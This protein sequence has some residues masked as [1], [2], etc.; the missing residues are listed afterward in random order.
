MLFKSDVL[1]LLFLVLI[2][3][4]RANQS[5]SNPWYLTPE[6]EIARGPVP[7]VKRSPATSREPRDAV[8]PS[9]ATPPLLQ[10]H[11]ATPA[12]VGRGNAYYGPSLSKDAGALGIDGAQTHRIVV[13]V[14]VSV[15]FSG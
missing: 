3:H 10:W 15:R 11:Q 6:E 1:T 4:R 13:D 14:Y 8:R 5:M 2:P 9:N 12:V 7:A